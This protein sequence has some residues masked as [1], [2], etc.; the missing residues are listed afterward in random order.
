MKGIGFKSIN[1][2]YYVANVKTFMQN[3]ASVHV[4]V[5]QIFMTLINEC[6]LKARILVAFPA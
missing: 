5:I 3:R 4:N 6:S 1:T 2:P